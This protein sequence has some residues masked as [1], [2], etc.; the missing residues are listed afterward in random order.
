VGEDGVAPTIESWL[1]RIHPK[2]R[3]R[4][5]TAIQNHCDGKSPALQEDHRLRNKSGQWVWVRCRGRAAAFDD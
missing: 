3:P 1:D 2:D 5:M 4:I